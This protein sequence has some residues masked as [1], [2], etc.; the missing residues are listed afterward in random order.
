MGKVALR[1]VWL[2][3]FLQDTLLITVIADE[4]ITRTIFKI[5]HHGQVE[6]SF[7]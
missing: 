3:G 5:A 6:I 4:Q 2:V 7:T 1:L